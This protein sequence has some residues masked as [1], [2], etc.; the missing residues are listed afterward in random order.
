MGVRVMTEPVDEIM[1]PGCPQC[2]VKH[3]CAA[4]SYLADRRG[5]A[6]T[7][8]EHE[9]LVARA[10]VNLSECA[11]GYHSHLHLAVG[12]LERAETLMAMTA[13]GELASTR[14]VRVMLI[15]DGESAVSDAL[16]ALVRKTP[17]DAFMWAHLVEP[18]REFGLGQAVEPTE[19]SIVSAISRIRDENL[20]FGREERT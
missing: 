3:L 7:A 2:A 4:L 19:E 5:S 12:L 20:L 8:D 15:R 13:C 11:A 9:I 16:K 1:T 6:G 17:L 14:E 18:A 10:C